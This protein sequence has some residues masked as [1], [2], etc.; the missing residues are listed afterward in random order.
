MN[1]KLSEH[2]TYKKLLTF[3]FPSVMMMVFTSIY[4]VVD[5]FFVSNYVG[6][7]PFAALNLIYPFIQII[8]ALGF[9][10]GAG[11]SAIIGKTLGEGDNERASRYFSLITYTTIVL[12]A[13]FSAI[14][15][16]FLRP[17]SI[18]LGADEA[19][20][21]YCVIY[22]RILLIGM[23]P[24]MLQ[25]LFQTL[26]ITAEKPHLG[27]A[28]T[29]AAGCTNMF[30]DWLFVGVLELGIAGAAWA[31]VISELIGGIIPLV[32]FFV[33]NSS[34]IHLGKTK[35]EPKILLKSCTNG[36]SELVSNIS[37]SLVGILYNFRLMK[38]AGED[39]V[40][41]YGVIMYVSFIF[42]AI[43]FGYSIGVAPIISYHFGAKNTNELKN[44]FKKSITVMAFF[45][46]VMTILAE[47]TSLPLSRLFVDY[48][49]E[50]VL[51]TNRGF[52]IFS[53]AYL[54]IGLNVFGSSLFTALN[55]GVTSAI[56][57]FVRMLVLQVITVIVLPL[58]WDLDGIWAAEPVA[59]II[60][61]GITLY[62]F[63]KFK[64]KYHY[65]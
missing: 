43:F 18:L 47:I 24:L 16:P 64:D 30:L 44:L 12:G 57:S 65:A 32:Y 59:D 22:G 14:G 39:G 19:M 52:M 54:V 49:A 41:A 7:T 6:K 62:F 35:M 45:G 20:I 55:D 9:M 58:I 11:G 31:T 23:V 21:E 2:F 17:I 5:G 60:S 26:L 50:L 10:M 4:G 8:S 29:V 27:F 40:A 13:V 25:C 42:V 56:I 46:I 28:V 51:I 1:I 37:A 53:A 48:D 34:L 3:V 38:Y 33:P 63:I 61:F 36:A 15:I